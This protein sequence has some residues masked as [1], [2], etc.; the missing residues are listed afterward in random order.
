MKEKRIQGNGFEIW[1]HRTFVEVNM[2]CF[3]FPMNQETLNSM[4]E[5]LTKAW[6]E[7]HKDNHANC[8]CRENGV[9]S[10]DNPFNRKWGGGT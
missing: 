5:G 9:T 8:G 7:I 6:Y 1:L 2:G 3:R 10:F 4:L